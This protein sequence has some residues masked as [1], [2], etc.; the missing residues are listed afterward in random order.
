MTTAEHF[1]D[2]LSA[3]PNGAGWIAK[4]PAHEDRQPSLSIDEG[5]DGK[6]LLKCFAG[7]TTENIVAAIGLTLRDLFPT[8][9]RSRSAKPAPVKKNNGVV[10]AFDF[11]GECVAVLNA[12]VLQMASQK[13]TRRY[14]AR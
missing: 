9:S 8:R 11:H 14:V 10:A 4:C 6:V 13:R 2:L 1:V 7:C 3:K 12:C 5:A